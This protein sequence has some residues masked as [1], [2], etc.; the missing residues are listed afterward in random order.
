MVSRCGPR[1]PSTRIACAAMPES[2]ALRGPDAEG[3]AEPRPA[4]GE[5]H[6]W[7]GATRLHDHQ[8]VLVA[9]REMVWP[10]Q[11]APSPQWRKAHAL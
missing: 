8:A 1:L 4:D 7:M 6:L 10:E 5:H 2:M 11:A 3:L 9:L